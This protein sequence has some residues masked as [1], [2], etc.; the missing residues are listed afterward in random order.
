MIDLLNS[1]QGIIIAIIIAIIAAHAF[2]ILMKNIKPLQK[3]SKE[4]GFIL[5]LE[6]IIIIVLC[7]LTLHSFLKDDFD[8]GHSVV[9]YHDSLIFLLLLLFL[10]YGS[11][12]IYKWD[13]NHTSSS[14]P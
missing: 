7:Y 13:H 2:E 10:F 14:N 11:W 4:R 12:R 5:F 6:A 9:W 1:Y 8:K 3:W